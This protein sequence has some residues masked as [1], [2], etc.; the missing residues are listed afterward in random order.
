MRLCLSKFR[1]A[2][3]GSD[4]ASFKI[5][6]EAVLEP[7]WRY[8]LEGHDCTNLEAAI[9]QFGGHNRGSLDMHPEAMIEKLWWP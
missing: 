7:V 6:L 1:D 4:Q 5:H 9:E 2:L 8:V 3:G